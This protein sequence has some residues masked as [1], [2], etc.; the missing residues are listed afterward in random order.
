MVER[1]ILFSGPMVRAI[2]ESRKTVTRRILGHRIGVYTKDDAP[3]VAESLV[4][5]GSDGSP[6]DGEVRCRY[7]VPGDRLYVKETHRVRIAHSC[8]DTCD[9]GDVYVEY[10]ADGERR[11]I[12]EYDSIVPEGW[13]MPKRAHRDSWTPSIYMPRWAS[14]IL[15]EVVSVRVERL[16][17]ITEKDAC[18]EG[19][20]SDAEGLR[21]LSHLRGVDA[22]RAVPSRLRS[23]RDAF[24]ELWDDINGKRAPWASNPW[25]WRVE[26]RKIEEAARG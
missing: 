24:R 15:L 13:T 18:A 5:R 3:N 12:S 10:A 7:G 20:K 17:T 1:P 9:C 19:C 23:T 6:E 2:R 21:A 14:R 16:H 22:P 11:H 4:R 25:V 8:V 26:F